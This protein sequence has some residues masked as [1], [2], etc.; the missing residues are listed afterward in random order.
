MISTRYSCKILT[1]LE[2]TNSRRRVVLYG[3]TD[4]Q[5]D[6]QVDMTK[7]MSLSAIVQTLQKPIKYPDVC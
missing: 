5:A 3:R 2:F 6:T 1:K 4:G 7:L